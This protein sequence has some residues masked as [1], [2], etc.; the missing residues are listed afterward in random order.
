MRAKNFGFTL[1]ELMI[2]VAIVGI[3]AA[4]AYPS[5]RNSVIKSNRSDAK[6]ALSQ[7]VQELEKCFTRYNT[8][9]NSLTTPCPTSVSL[10][11]SGITSPA[12]KYLVTGTPTATTYTLTATPQGAQANDTRC[13][14]FTLQD[15]NT[16]GVSG[17]GGV[18][19]CW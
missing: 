7:A 1:M 14:N 6:I 13:G 8:Y 2:T 3:L 17:A 9:V 10:A 18:A 4:I 15:N 19:A 5:Y 11:G 16:R 12:Q